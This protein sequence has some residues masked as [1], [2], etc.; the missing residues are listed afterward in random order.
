[1][2]SGLKILLSAY[3]CEPDMGSEP[4]VGWN[5]VKQTARFHEVWV[6][7]RA[8]NKGP[9]QKT[10]GRGLLPNVHWIYFDLPRWM[11]FWKKGSRGI[12]LY[13]YLWQIGIYFEGKRLHK[14]VGFDLVHHVTFVNYWMPSLMSLL[15]IPFLWGPVGGGESTPPEFLKTYSLRGKL[16]EFLRDTA[17]R[18]GELDPLVRLTAKRT[19]LALATTMGTRKRLKKIGCKH[20]QV[21]SESGMSQNEISDLQAIPLHNSS[22]FRILSIGRLLHWKGFHLSLAAFAQFLKDAPEAEYWLIGDGPE[23]HRLETLAEN[24]NVAKNVKF[25]GGIPRK[26]VFEKLS[27]SDV[28]VHPSL[29]DSGGWV[30][31]EAMAAGRPVICLDLGGPAIQVT[32]STGIKVAAVTPEQ[33]IKDM[34]LAMR[35]IAENPGLCV[36]M[37]AAGRQRVAGYFNWDIKGK[38]INVVY[39]Q[40][41]FN[42]N[43]SLS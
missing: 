10:L 12:H 8:N 14:K 7:T 25:L 27:Q 4:G 24:L 22:P 30:C 41:L 43:E 1:M 17:R 42:K 35:N 39:N 40:I 28:L 36:D 33:T 21:F 3:A 13:Y 15:P 6:I 34:A 26:L 23:R 18:F 16:Y 2:T 20:I 31:L 5:Q 11:R 38:W 19:N 29:H 37:S 32:R 9:I